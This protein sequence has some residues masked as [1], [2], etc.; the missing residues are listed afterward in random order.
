[1][2]AP[3]VVIVLLVL[4]N[5]V[6]AMGELALISARPARLRIL[7][8]NGVKGAQRAQRLAEDPQ[9]FLPTV[10]VGITLVSILEGT[11]G[12][13]QIEAGL[14]PWLGG[15]AL[16]R[17]FA[18]E[19]SIA[20]VVV[21][22]T[23]LML[24]L[25]ELVP[26]QLA[27]RHPEIIAA[28]LSLLLEGLARLV[29]PAVWVLGRSS[30]LVLRL[31]GVGSATREALTEEELKAYIA[32]GAQSGVLEQAERDM[33]ERLL[34]LADR[35][36][37]AI[38]TPRNELVWIERKA[39][40]EELRRMLRQTAYTRIVVCDGGVDNPVGVILAKDMLDCLLDGRPVSIEAGLRKPVVVPDTISAFDMVERMRT[41][42]AGMALVL[43]EYGS[44]EG[45][46]TASDLFE[47]IVGEHHEAGGAPSA[48]LAPDDVLVLDG[49][50]PVDELKDRLGLADLPDEGSYHTL[51]GLILALLRRV[52][53]AGDKVVFSGWLFEVQEMDQRRVMRVRASRQAFAEN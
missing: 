23:S 21:S 7:H 20:I 38:M 29:R 22:I 13:T 16:L 24:V 14:T 28:R 53:A 49:F 32:E 36:V 40:R 1:M 26:K 5:G 6:F 25:G 33:I 15:F 10:Q 4:L 11:Y 37:R 35:P 52:P 44:F 27:L 31:M 18:P 48:H 47:A 8:R 46:V 41:V 43:D 42:A 34:R 51:G 19:L 39:S 30:N 2:I 12:G 3:L 50:M 9:S 17:P 45:V